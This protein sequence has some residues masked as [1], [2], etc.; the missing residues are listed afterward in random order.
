MNAPSWTDPLD[1]E[2]HFHLRLSK[3]DL[4]TVELSEYDRAVMKQASH[5]HATIAEVLLA[6]EA[7]AHNIYHATQEVKP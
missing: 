2:F 1:G 4:L 3:H 6:L 7:I 5:D